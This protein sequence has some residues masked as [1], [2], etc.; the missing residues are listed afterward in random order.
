M[1]FNISVLKNPVYVWDERRECNVINWDV[2]QGDRNLDLFF[3]EKD[4]DK[5]QNFLEIK[6]A[7]TKQREGESYVE[8]KERLKNE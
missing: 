8:H 6:L 7:S 2:S 5:L 3:D 4:F 1:S